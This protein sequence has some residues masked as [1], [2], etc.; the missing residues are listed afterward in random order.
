MYP[1]LSMHIKLNDTN[2]LSL[3]QKGAHKQNSQFIKQNVAFLSAFLLAN[4][5][6]C[7]L[8][9]SMAEFSGSWIQYFAEITSLSSLKMTFSKQSQNVTTCVQHHVLNNFNFNFFH[10]ISNYNSL[11]NAQ[12]ANTNEARNYL[13]LFNQFQMWYKCFC[14]LIIQTVFRSQLGKENLNKT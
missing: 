1:K 13:K 12:K 7:F 4:C 3:F 6:S 2:I 11:V 5:I 8:L 14:I 9:Y 10:D